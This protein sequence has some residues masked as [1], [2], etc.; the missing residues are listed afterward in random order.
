V[1]EVEKDFKERGQ[2]EIVWLSPSEAAYRVREVE[3]KSLIID[4]KP[5]KK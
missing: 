4:F 1:A 2:R 3:L 5:K